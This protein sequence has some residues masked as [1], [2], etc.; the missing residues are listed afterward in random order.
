[1]LGKLLVLWLLEGKVVYQKDLRDEFSGDAIFET[2]S[3]DTG[4]AF[5]GLVICLYCGAYTR[6]LATT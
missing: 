4:T 5:Q 3:F 6:T 2:D 1:M